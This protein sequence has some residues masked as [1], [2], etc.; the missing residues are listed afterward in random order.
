MWSD[1]DHNPCDHGGVTEDTADPAARTLRL[2]TLLSSRRAWNG[3]ELA[4]R[5]GVSPRTLRRDLE[6]LQRL[7][8]HVR[9]RPGPGGYYSLEA[10]SRVPP[11]TFDDDEVLAL[12]AG[13]RMVEDRVADDA[14]D[15]ALAKLLQVLPRRLAS[16][17]REVSAGSETVRRRP[18]DLDLDLLSTLTQAAARN[19]AVEFDYRDQ[20]GRD[21]RRRLDTLRCVHS[22]GQWYVVGFDLDR[23]DWRLFRIDRVANLRVGARVSAARDGPGDDLFTW[24]TTDFGRQT[25]QASPASR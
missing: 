24:F 13:L 5:L 4:R 14:A 17:A 2:L 7:D 6:R 18:A 8:Y 25:G 21:S 15:R 3:A 19:H 9:G 22:R 1:P 23:D 10:G 12:V 20:A 11:L 16:V